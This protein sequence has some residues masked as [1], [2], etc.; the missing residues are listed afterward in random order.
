MVW[1]QM[2]ERPSPLSMSPAPANARH[3]STSQMF[4]NHPA[5]VIASPHPAAPNTTKSP[6][7]RTREVQPLVR[8]S[9]AEPTDPAA[10]ISP[11]AHSASSS[12]AR[13]GKI[14]F[15]KAKNIAARSIAYV[16]RSTGLLHAYRAPSAMPRRDG[17]S[18]SCAAGAADSR[19]Q[20][21]TEAANV[22]IVSPYAVA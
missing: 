17:F 16:P 6:C 10:Y 11:S 1:F 4:A 5:A 7:R 2:V 12:S 9:T 3:T 8:A 15:G 21:S 20:S 22:R 19:V 18:A 13:N 14:V